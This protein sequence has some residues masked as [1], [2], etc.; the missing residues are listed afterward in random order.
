MLMHKVTEADSGM[1]SQ[2]ETQGGSLCG[3]FL[4]NDLIQPK[5]VGFAGFSSGPFRWPWFSLCS[6]W[7]LCRFTLKALLC[8]SPQPLIMLCMRG[9]A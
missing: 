1:S 8:N 3:L 5:R 9:E 7:L 4:F 2:E 6:V